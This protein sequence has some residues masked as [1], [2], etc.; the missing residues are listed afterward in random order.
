MKI[1][2]L[3][4]KAYLKK[5]IEYKSSLDAISKYISYSMMQSNLIKH[6]HYAVDFKHYVF[7]SFYPLE[8]D[9]TYKSNKT[10]TFTIRSL[11]SKFTDIM[12]E[13]LRAN[14]NNPNFLV[15]DAVKKEIKE[16][17]IKELYTLTPTV[18]TIKKGLYWT[19]QKDGDITKLLKQLQDNL[20][21]KYKSFYGEE[22][23]V[24]QN[25]IQAIE[26][27]N[28]LP[29]SIYITKN[30]QKIR[31]FGNKFKIIPN[32]D[33]TSQ[34]LAFLA[35]GAGLGEKNSFGAGFVIAKGKEMV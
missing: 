10:Y 31:L 24:K 9:K 7:G 4:C 1:F 30:K 15:I 13:L 17:F 12:Q 2:E 11:D 34:K 18:V 5:D 19:I 16:F 8:N 23:E 25:F 32:E 29:Q 22:L 3:K 14:I 27:K 6:L 20:E 28:K 35:L 21:K 26:L 33:E